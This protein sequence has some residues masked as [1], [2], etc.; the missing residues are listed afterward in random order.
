MAYEPPEHSEDS[1]LIKQLNAYPIIC[2]STQY[3]NLICCL[4]LQLLYL[5]IIKSHSLRLLISL[6]TLWS[7]SNRL[8][9]CTRCIC[10]RWSLLQSWSLSWIIWFKCFLALSGAQGVTTFVHLSI[11]ATVAFRSLLGLS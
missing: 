11:L 1:K 9:V 2:K 6:I 5:K 8:Q 10:T 7:N 3:M 4:I